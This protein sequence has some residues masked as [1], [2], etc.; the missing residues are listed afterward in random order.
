MTT[1]NKV[2]VKLTTINYMNEIYLKPHVGNWCYCEHI[3]GHPNCTPNHLI[4][5]SII[6][7]VYKNGNFE[8][9]HSHFFVVK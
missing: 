8:T 5:T 3:S 2:Y 4:S 9:K 7:K 6:V 1:K